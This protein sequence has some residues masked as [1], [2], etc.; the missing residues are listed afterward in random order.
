MDK[1]LLWKDEYNI[2]VASIDKEHQKLFHVVNKLL[3]LKEEDKNNPDVCREGINYLKEHAIKHFE[4]E[5]KYMAS[6]GY[7][8][9]KMHK[10]LHRGFREDTLPALEHE[11]ITNNYSPDVVEHF[12]A[13]CAGWLIGHTLTEDFAIT[14]K[15][16]SK[17]VNLLPDEETTMMRQVITKL[18]YDMFQ[19][20]SQVISDT[21]GGERFGHGIY[22]R[23]VYGTEQKNKNWEI[24]L[25]FEEKLLINTI[26]RIMGVRSDNLDVMLINAVRY[27]ARQFVWRVMQHFPSL[28]LYEMKEENL[29]SYDQFQEEFEKKQPQI[30]L[31]FNTS[32]GYFSYCVFAPHLLQDGIGTPIEANNAN[33][34]I[35]KYLLKRKEEP[36]QKMLIVDDS[37]TIRQGMKRLL[38]TD[39]EVSMASSGASAI[40]AITLDRPDLIL[41]DYEMPVCNGRHVLEMLRTEEEFA[42]IPVIFLTSRDDKESINEVLKLKPNGYLLKTLRPAQIKERIDKY[43]KQ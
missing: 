8:E 7:D 31:L 22:Y 18:L 33:K 4:E 9:L 3:T 16:M 10:R 14:R 12:L 11:L 19:L 13:V 34:E 17:W 39:Y 41:L 43:F 40:R 6:I 24:F 37:I 20:K 30:S 21:Y 1:Q 15:K 5:E 25:V 32:E 27:T 28:K 26:G 29:L 23:L 36:K 38:Q 2:G 42:D 35:E